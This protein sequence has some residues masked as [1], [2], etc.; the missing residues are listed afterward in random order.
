MC[1]FFFFFMIRRPPSSTLT[2]TLFPSTTLF[3][4]HDVVPR[5]GREGSD[6]SGR[7]RLRP[8]GEPARHRGGCRPAAQSRTDEPTPVYLHFLSDRFCCSSEPYAGAVG[9]PHPKRLRWR[10]AGSHVGQQGFQP[11]PPPLP[12]SFDSLL[13]DVP[14]F[15]CLDS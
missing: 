8:D 9:D 2:D 3:R 13:A 5:H 1:V 7:H 10:I 11:P 14:H 6:D 12:P 15:P 4:S